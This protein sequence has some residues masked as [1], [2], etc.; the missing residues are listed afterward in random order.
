MICDVYFNLTKKLYSI[1]AREGDQ[2]GRVI[3]HCKSVVMQNVAFKVSQASRNRVLRDKQKNVHAVARGV[4]VS[5]TGEGF[6]VNPDQVAPLDRLKQNGKPF[7]YCPYRSGA[8]QT[9]ES[10][11]TYRDV[12]NARELLLDTNGNR[13]LIIA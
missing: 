1:R 5:A 4:L 8:F 7:T 3:G 2:K 11:G 10:D 6:T 12:Q 13:Y 9:V